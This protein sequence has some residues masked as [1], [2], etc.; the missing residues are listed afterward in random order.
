LRETLRERKQRLDEVQQLYQLRI[1]GML[2][3]ARELLHH[4]G[5]PALLGPQR[6]EAIDLIRVVD[7][8]H[9]ARL[10]R[11]RASYEARLN[12]DNHPA[13]QAH[14]EQLRH[15][16][17]E[18][19]ALLIAGGHV[20]VLLNRLRLFGISELAE[21]LPIIA[22]SAGAMCMAEWIVLFHHHPPQG[23]NDTQVAAPGLALAP[24]I[25]PF[26]HATRRLWLN[27]PP[28]VALLARRF[29]PWVCATLDPGG[30]VE[31]TEAGWQG[32][33]SARRLGEDG[34]LHEVVL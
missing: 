30:W 12:W 18:C 10:S 31:W 11:I 24:G 28:R 27:S 29:A 23:H 8:Q 6:R 14:R 16:L 13:V 25:V 33:G 7:R 4:P 5:D 17:L 19:S 22:W 34:N 3:A 26:P 1:A 9:L 15:E 20:L 2:D 32:H 21:G